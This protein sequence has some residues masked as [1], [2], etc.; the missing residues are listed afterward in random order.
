[1]R[2]ERIRDW[3]RLKHTPY[4]VVVIPRKKK[5][6]GNNMPDNKKNFDTY[7][8]GKEKRIALERKNA[9]KTQIRGE[10]E[11]YRAAKRESFKHSGLGQTLSFMGKV[12][13]SAAKMQKASKGRKGKKHRKGGWQPPKWMY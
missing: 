6:E 8:A 1:M 5:K 3:Y 2:I 4:G 12:G 9:M 11:K 10:K 13:E 7:R